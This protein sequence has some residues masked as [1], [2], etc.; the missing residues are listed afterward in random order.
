MPSQLA[1]LLCLIFIV[2]L[3]YLG[4]NRFD[5]KSKALWIPLIWIFLAGSREL[6][7][8]LDLMTPGD[9]FR[10]AMEGNPI[11]GIAYLLLIGS[12]IVVILSRRPDWGAL[13]IRNSWIWLY[14]LFGLLSVT[15]SD[16]PEISF[17]R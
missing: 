12:G 17:V 14:F 6:S 16:Y 1:T 9:A 15:W 3:F 2:I 11:D 4:E 7:Q 10:R 13:L 5:S 8:W